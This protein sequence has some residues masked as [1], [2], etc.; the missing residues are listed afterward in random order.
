MEEAET[1]FGYTLNGMF[2]IL[3]HK[4]IYTGFSMVFIKFIET[5]TIIAQM[6]SWTKRRSSGNQPWCKGKDFYF[7]SYLITFGFLGTDCVIIGITEIKENV[8]DNID[9]KAFCAYQ[10]REKGHKEIEI[11][12]ILVYNIHQTPGHV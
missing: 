4:N 5:G 3:P 10:N 7:S 2:S 6:L 11:I 8:I 1:Q 9:R 12:N